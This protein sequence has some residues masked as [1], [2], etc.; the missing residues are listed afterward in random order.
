MYILI[1]ILKYI[2]L[3]LC[4]LCIKYDYNNLFNF[5]TGLLCIYISII[6]RKSKKNTG[7]SSVESDFS[8]AEGIPIFQT[9]QLEDEYT[10][11]D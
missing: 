3:I 7:T 11:K 5:I 4:C 10:Q 6:S 9:F 8:K 2:L 1:C